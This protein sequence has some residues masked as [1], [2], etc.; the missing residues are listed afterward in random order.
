[1]EEL[2]SVIVPIYKVEKYLR[3]CIDSILRQSYENL[4]ILLVEDGSPDGCGAICDAYA[5]KDS[6]IRVLHK[7]NGGLSDARNA[8]MAKATGEWIFFVDADD[9]IHPQMIEKLYRAAK[10][11]NAKLAWCEIQEVEEETGLTSPNT[12]KSG[13]A[14][15]TA[16][17]GKTDGVIVYTRQEAEMQMYTVGGMQQALVTWNKLYHHTLFERE[18]KPIQFP[19]GK[20]YEDG[21][22]IYKLIYGA[23]RVVSIPDSLYYYR[24]RS[25]SIMNK[26]SHKTYEAAIEAGYERMDFY[27]RH[28]EPELYRAELNLT[29]YSVIRFYQ[30]NKT[31]KDRK[32]LREHFADLY[33]N[34]FKKENWSM[35]KRIRMASFRVGNPCYLL[36]SSFE[37]IYNKLTG[38]SSS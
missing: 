18:G 13:V 9:Y 36:I 31:K 7:E 26:N 33:Q 29:I 32:I 38:R 35:G 21:Y 27:Q 6:R 2:I 23:D 5:G 8:G 37:S 16:E 11:Y 34:Y 4:E 17:Q 25:G 22:T 12:Q 24:Q 30:T 20:I 19:K 3:C 1:M 15:K 10:E 14:E 28:E